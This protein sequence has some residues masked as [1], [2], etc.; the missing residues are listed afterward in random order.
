MPSCVIG[1]STSVPVY[2]PCPDR[3]CA[4]CY[5]PAYALGGRVAE[6]CVKDD[7]MY[8]TELAR[9]G[10]DSTTWRRLGGQFSS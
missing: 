5:V 8:S 2:C 3:P 6:S 9:R 4:Q 1:F 7:V 10:I